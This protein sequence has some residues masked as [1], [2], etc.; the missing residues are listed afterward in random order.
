LTSYDLKDLR[1]DCVI[2]PL[3]TTLDYAPMAE[4][5]I[6]YGAP[7]NAKAGDLGL[8]PLHLAVTLGHLTVVKT[9][10]GHRADIAAT[11]RLGV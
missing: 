4:L 11:D 5:L 10:L 8:T 2:K 3:V 6:S 9:L 1:R 7:I